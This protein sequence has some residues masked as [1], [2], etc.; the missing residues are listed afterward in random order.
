MLY[1][2][3]FLAG[4]YPIIFCFSVILYVTVNKGHLLILREDI[5][6]KLGEATYMEKQIIFIVSS[7]WQ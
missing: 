5:E 7:Q 1:I 6:I 3:I 2:I 4:H